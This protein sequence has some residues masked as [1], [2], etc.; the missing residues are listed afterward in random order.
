MTIPCLQILICLVNQHAQASQGPT[1]GDVM[2]ASAT[3]Q[4]KIGDSYDQMQGMCES[5]LLDVE[6]SNLLVFNKITK[7]GASRS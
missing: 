1:N 3:T 4:Q 6:S 2:G 7:F 5:T